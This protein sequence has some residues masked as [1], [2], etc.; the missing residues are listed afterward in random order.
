MHVADH[1]SL[2]QLQKLADS[3]PF[4][5]RFLKLR[6]LIPACSGMKASDIAQA[7]GCARRSVQN[8]VARYNAEGLAGLDHRPGGGRPAFLGLAELKRLRVRIDA[9]PQP[10]DGVYTLRGPEIHAPLQNASSASFTA[11]PPFTPCSTA[12]VPHVWTHAPNISTPTPKPGTPS[13]KVGQDLEAIA[14]Q[15]PGRRL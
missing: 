5:Y 2:V 12:W 8:W 11:W 9:G 4:K 13:K 15:H 3:E 6:D 7:F 14:G 1:L 10:E